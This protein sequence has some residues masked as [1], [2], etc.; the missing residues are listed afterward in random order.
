MNKQQILPVLADCTTEVLE[1]MFFV[2][3]LIEQPEMV[4]VEDAL[5]ADVFFHG[6]PSGHLTMLVSRA[7]ARS[8]A[9]DFLGEDE[10]AVSQQQ[11]EEVIA[12]LSN[13]ICGSVLSRIESDATFRLEP[14]RVRW[15][16]SSVA[17][18]GAA[19]HSV[20][21][22]NGSLAIAFHTGPPLCPRTA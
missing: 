4:P 21:F 17:Q 20:G 13:I 11:V 18:E 16:G 1:E 3:S 22:D 19:I 14:P 5:I 8:I 9:A 2:S 6:A 15:A 12:E 7:S 10:P